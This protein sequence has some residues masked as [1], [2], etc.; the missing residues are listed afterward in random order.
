MPSQN[1]YLV[2]T[3]KEPESWTPRGNTENGGGGA[4][5]KLTTAG[6]PYTA[7]CQ[8]QTELI[9]FGQMA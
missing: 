6:T 9:I 3:R 5:F 7:N 4:D 2:D 8:R 1:S